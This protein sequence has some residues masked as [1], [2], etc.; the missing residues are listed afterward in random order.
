MTQPSATEVDAALDRAVDAIRN[1]PDVALA[2]HVSP[3]G[4]ALGSM[5]GST[6]C[7]APSRRASHPSRRRSSSHRTTSSGPGSIS[8]RRRTS[9]R[10][11]RP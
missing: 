6:S 2:C 8:S 11:S 3:D 1:A 4:D 9:S 5:L 7:A 10:A